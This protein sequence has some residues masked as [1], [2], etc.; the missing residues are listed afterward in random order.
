MFNFQAGELV[1]DRLMG[2]YVMGDLIGHEDFLKRLRDYNDGTNFHC[3]LGN[4][5]FRANFSSLK[6]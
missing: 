3:S 1:F 2:Y 5:Q 4:Y 6:I